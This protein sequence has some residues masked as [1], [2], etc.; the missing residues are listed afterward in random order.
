MHPEVNIVSSVENLIV[1]KVDEQLI[2]IKLDT[3][4]CLKKS[5]WNHEFGKKQKNIVIVQKLV[6]GACLL[7]VDWRSSIVN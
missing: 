6:E 1:T 4:Y 2:S 7:E 5:T 3:P